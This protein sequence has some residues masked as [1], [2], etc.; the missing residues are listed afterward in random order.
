M[1]ITKLQGGLGNQIF[2]WAYGKSL[3]ITHEIDLYL[4]TTYY[5]NQI[6]DTPRKYELI[7]FPNLKHNK[8]DYGNKRIIQISDNFNYEKLHY[9][10]NYSYYLNG[11]WQSEKYFLNISDII[12]DELQPDDETLEKLKSKVEDN[13][14]SLHIRRTDYVT[15]NGFHPV[16]TI[17]Y[18]NKA[19]ETI[20]EYN[21][22]LVFSDDI[23]WCKDNLKYDNIFF[24]ENQDNI[25]DL[26]LMSLCAHNIIA[27]SSFSWWGAWL[28]KNK[29]KT[30]IAPKNWFGGS[31]ELNQSDI[32][33][34]TW[35][36]I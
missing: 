5:N 20:G 3:S 15:S 35:I 22:L 12:R 29:N 25:E 33:P 16:Q 14:V 23:S 19:L 7:K 17:E 9:D 6:G 34:D 8:P 26:W 21:Q 18:Y 10:D 11:F 31:S 27:N 4:D 1:I 2:Q 32:V 30:V 36:K 13:S 28:N 24:V